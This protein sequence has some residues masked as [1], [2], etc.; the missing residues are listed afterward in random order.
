MMFLHIF[1]NGLQDSYPYTVWLY[2]RT[3]LGT[4]IQFVE[5]A[6]EN[7]YLNS[8]ELEVLIKHV[9]TGSPVLIF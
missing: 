7:S 5:C 4:L 1:A 9:I 6:I 8:A 3:W 2:V